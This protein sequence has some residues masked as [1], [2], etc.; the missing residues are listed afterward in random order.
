MQDAQNRKYQGFR[1]FIELFKLDDLEKALSDHKGSREYDAVLRYYFAC[2]GKMELPRLLEPLALLKQTLSSMQT[3]GRVRRDV[4]SPLPDSSR[5]HAPGLSQI[6]KSIADFETRAQ[7]TVEQM[8]TPPSEVP[9]NMHFVWLGGGLGDIQRDYLNLWKRVMAAKGY[10]LNLWYDSDAMLVHQTNKLIVEAAKVDALEQINQQ[11]ISE[12]A[13]ATLY[14]ERAIVLK[15]QMYAHI[16]AGIAAG[17][18]ADDARIDLLARA[19]GQD[20]EALRELSARNLRSI[21][22]IGDDD[23]ALRDLND[24]ESPLALQDVYERET[25]LRGNLAAASDVVRVEVLARE[26]GSYADV[27][28]LPPLA[29]RLG[30]TDISAWQID[31]RLGALQLLL[32]HNPDWMPGRQAIRDR[33]TSYAQRIPEAHRDA[34]KVFANSRPALHDVFSVP[35]GLLARPYELRAAADANTTNN[36]FLLAH[37]GAGMIQAV[38]DRMRLSYEIIDRTANLAAQR[39]IALSDAERLQPLAHEIVEAALGP[40]R[41]LTMEEE[42]FASFLAGAAAS[43]FSDGIRPQSEQTIYL[44]GPAAVRDGMRNYGKQHFTPAGADVLHNELK[45]SSAAVINR[46]TEEEQDHSWKNNEAFSAQWVVDEQAR[47]REGQYT[48]RYSGDIAQL[49]K[50]STVEFQSGWPV[51]EG[52]EVL[53]SE[54]LQRLLDHWGEPF[55]HAMRSGLDGVIRFDTPMPLSFEE[56]QTIRMQ[57][58]RILPPVFSDDPEIIN[59]GLDDILLRIAKGTLHVVQINPLQRLALGALLGAESLDNQRFMQLHDDL[60]N[61]ANSVGELGLS[62]RY[63]AIERHFYKRRPPGFTEGLA[64]VIDEAPQLSGTALALK[65]RTMIEAHTPYQWGRQVARVQRLATLEH[66]EQVQSR[67]EQVLRDV[68]AS[69]VKLVPQDLLLQGAGETIAGRCYPLALVMSAA[70][71]LGEQASQRLRDRFYL[72]VV[73][74]EHDDSVAFLDALEEMRDVPLSEVGTPQGRVGLSDIQARLQASDGNVGLMLNSDNHV[75]LV[76]KTVA[77]GRSRLHFFDPNFGLFEFDDPLAFQR[78]LHKFFVA[79]G[80]ADYYAAFGE[81]GHPMFDLIQLH[82]DQVSSLQLSRGFKVAQLLQADT[83]P[84]RPSG[85]SVRRR[86]ASARGRT[87]SGNAH[88]G[89]CLLELDSRWWGQQIADA[90]VGLQELHATPKPLVPLFET[91]ETTPEGDYRVSLI[92]PADPGHVTQVTSKDARLSRIKRWLS[93]QF[94]TLA[95]KPRMHSGQP[96]LTEAGSVHTLNAG[97]AIQT[98]MLSLRDREGDDRTLSLAVRLHGYVNYAQLA[99][100]LVVDGVGLMKLYEAAINEEKVIARTC[101]PVVGEALSHVANEGVGSLLGLANVGF[102]IY[103]LATAKNQVDVAR[104]GTQLAFDYA[105]FVTGLGGL[106]AAATGAA[107][108]AAFLGGAG[109][110]LGGLAIGVAA[111]AQG[112]AVIA[113]EAKSVGLFFD[114][115]EKAYGGAGYTFDDSL[116]AWVVEPSSLIID[117]LDLKAGKLLL[118]SPKLYRLRDHFGVPDV[119]TDDARALNIREQLGISSQI[120]RAFPAGQ[121]IVLPCT[122]H[123]YYDYEYKA[124]PFASWRHDTGFDTARRLEKKDSAGQWQFLFSFYSFPSHYVV[125]RLF[126]GY[127]HTTIEVRLDTTDRQLIVPMLPAAWRGLIGYKLSGAASVCTV[128]LNSGIS[129]ELHA[130]SLTRNRWVLV[131]D[132]VSQDAVR[133]DGDALMIA[134]IKVEF[135]GRGLHDIVLALADRRVYSVSRASAKLSVLEDTAPVGLDEQALLGHYKSMVREHRLVLPYTPVNRYLI[136]FEPPQEPRYTK[137]WYDAHEDRFLFVRNEDIVDADQALLAVV[138]AGSAYFYEPEDYLIW[139]VD[140][141]SG[142]LQ[143]KYRLLLMPGEGSIQSIE[144]DAQGMIHVVQTCVDVLENKRRISYVI[145]DRQVLLSAV[146]LEAAP[147]LRTQAFADQ[148]LTDWRS[149]LGDYLPHSG[150]PAK[151]GDTTVE[152][153][154]APFVAV[155]WKISPSRRDMVWIRSHDRLLIN[156]LPTAGRP[157]GWDDSI[158]NLDQLMLL[159]PAQEQEVFVIYDQTARSLCRLERTLSDGVANWMHTWIEPERLKQVVM[160]QSGYVAITE[161][162]RFFNLSAD[163]QLRFGGLSESWLLNRPRWWLGLEAIAKRYPVERFAIVG[164][165]DHTGEGRLC[166]WYIEQRLLL[167]E[168]PNGEDMCL[169]GLTPERD[170]AWLFEPSSGEIRSQAYVEPQH[171]EQAF[172]SGLQLLSRHLLPASEREWEDW[173]FADVIRQDAGLKGVTVEGVELSL[174]FGENEKVTGVNHAWVAAQ[175]EHLISGL[176]ALLDSVEHDG[177]VSLEAE[178]GVR[179]W[180]DAENARLIRVSDTSLRGDLEL[181][182]TRHRQQVLLHE[183]QAGCVLAYPGGTR[184][185]PFAY[186]QRDAGVMV[187]EGEKRVPDLA[188]LVPDGVNTLILRAGQGAV[189]YHLSNALW[190]ERDSVIVDCRP[191]HGEA[192]MIPGKLVWPLS[193]PQRLELQIV[194]EHLVLIDPDSEHCLILR[195]VC[196]ADPALRGDVF[197]AL[198]QHPSLPVSQLVQWLQGSQGATGSATLQMLLSRDAHNS[199]QML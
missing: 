184:F 112:F 187:I 164:L 176:R 37:P 162:G 1:E 155:S 85:L 7:F 193:N 177:F 93:E 17:Q 39:G 71:A 60:D 125:H 166:A 13:L 16:N 20:A 48:T 31:A 159:A 27:D 36:A 153:W 72:A 49:L 151:D 46:A 110:M 70:L 65:K 45:I 123:T 28:N 157:R 154:P 67:V 100:G 33:Y 136:P 43:Y 86:L 127:R 179:Q 3:T 178:P 64:S 22:D 15:Q 192:A 124:L 156:P 97:F 40:L 57:P 167:S 121:R 89:R 21:T 148:T 77:D 152:W 120:I 141:R 59:A 23:L 175:G 74:P 186:V 79:R 161:D 81:P 83:L 185:G 189:T 69:S 170:Q 107:T 111:L 82:S 103:Q 163:G 73:E 182:G 94:S 150:L 190:L 76:T 144:A 78:E 104:F 30:T 10:T 42:I 165:L 90:T 38:I 139:Q 5:P 53:L 9:K 58:G 174:P 116:Q 132:W 119:D 142:L 66:R 63:A 12:N 8:R 34:L 68:D 55:A 51:I 147:Q 95:S 14:E 191:V 62:N 169:L 87:L 41:E 102:D 19:Y 122:P 173:T 160:T 115:L 158:R 101:A 113:E 2:I 92:D 6:S 98:L 61:L 128:M 137:A 145:H 131:A 172:A 195:E 56:R 143:H 146:I 50:Q 130:P 180:Y 75:M 26:G 29:S 197:L 133:M 117:C 44:T 109:V 126:P 4:D 91:L 84:G 140:A 129:L 183:R 99:H 118:G 24:L 88:L 96:D 47:W 198:G 18:S 11:T 114:H 52:R 188:A 106:A 108:A 196:S 35:T 134:D 32:D 149:V 168:A 181:L 194:G 138:V 135:S 199:F 171:L 80:M 54:P 25:R 105:S